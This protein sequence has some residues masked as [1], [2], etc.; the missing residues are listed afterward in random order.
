MLLPRRKR[1]QIFLKGILI[2]LGFVAAGGLVLAAFYIP[3]LRLSSI[4]IEG[5][6]P[7]ETK[8]LREEIEQILSQKYFYVFPKDNFI[9]FPKEKVEI[10]LKAKPRLREFLM[11]REFP[12]TLK[13]FLKERE[14]WAVWCQK[15]AKKS[16]LFLDA[17]GFAFGAAPAFS[18]TAVL[19]IIDERNEEF[20]GKN[21]MSSAQFQKLAALVERLPRRAKE[22]VSAIE[23]KI[24][25]N[26]F[27]LHLKSG[28]Y[29]TTD[30]ETDVDRALENLA[31]ALNS[32]IKES[33]A[34]LEYVDLRFP[35]K[36]FY[37]YK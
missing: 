26:T 32:E 29:I 8:I 33:R 22:E 10:L 4:V 23:I 7:A 15:D 21:I 30:E 31:L 27:R 18:G 28:W 11:E 5:L 25:G 36:V 19:K 12:S 6:S 13:I 34:K 20:I 14:T 24:S 3:S 9:L 1:Q 37:R 17:E 16:C 2:L 35:D